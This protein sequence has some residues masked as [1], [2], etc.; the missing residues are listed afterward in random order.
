MRAN[1]TSFNPFPDAPK[2][3][4]H[5]AP[6]AASQPPFAASLSSASPPAPPPG[7]P[8]ADGRP[9]RD[10]SASHAHAPAPHR[11]ANPLLAWQPLQSRLSANPRL[12]LQLAVELAVGAFSKTLAEAHDRGD[13]FWQQLEGYACNMSLELFG[14][15]MLVWLLSPVAGAHA[16]SL[17]KHFLQ[18]GGF[19]ASQRALGFVVKAA[20]FGLV[21]CVSSAVGQFATRGFVKAQGGDVEKLPKVL[22]NCLAWGGFMMVSSNVRYQLVNGFEQRVLE[23]VL[24]GGMVG[25]GITFAVRFGNSYVGGMQ[26]LPWARFWGVQ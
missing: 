20:Q 9:E 1:P 10:D 16:A 11:R 7:S 23:R 22:P 12:P 15:A 25:T 13:R 8:G 3:S 19:T 26:W 6:P 24:P 18:M 14:D 21:G 4:F 2:P 17:P 5:R